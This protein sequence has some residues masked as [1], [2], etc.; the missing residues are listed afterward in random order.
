MLK[1]IKTYLPRFEI[2]QLSSLILFG[3][4]FPQTSKNGEG[5]RMKSKL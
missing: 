4:T 5:L 3:I 2:M 1:S